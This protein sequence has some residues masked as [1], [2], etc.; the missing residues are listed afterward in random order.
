MD[1][2]LARWI[3]ASVASHFESVASGLSLPYFVEGVDERDDPTMRA[4]HAEM[5]V[6][7]P[8]IKEISSG[9]FTTEVGINV[10]LTQQMALSGAGAY[11]IVQWAGKFQ[12]IMLDPVPVY[13]YGPSAGDDDSLVGCLIVKKTRNDAVRVYHFG[14][15]SREDRIR[16]SEVDAVYGMDL[17]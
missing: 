16:Q 9:Y 1:E 14:Q 11:D 2:N 12:D 4:S 6:T 8:F 3:F 13:K 15:I 5:R 17:N 10:L 7:G